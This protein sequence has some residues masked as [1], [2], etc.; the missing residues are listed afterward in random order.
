[1]DAI[2]NLAERSYYSAVSSSSD[3]I[4]YNP[5]SSP[6][7]YGL[8]YHP[9]F[10]PWNSKYLQINKTQNPQIDGGRRGL[11]HER[12]FEWKGD[13]AYRITCPN[14]T[15]RTIVRDTQYLARAATCKR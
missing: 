4:P 5:K 14:D 3:S 2:F 12:P 11:G 10:V 6:T 8:T 13:R 7:S 9:L 15:I 1:M